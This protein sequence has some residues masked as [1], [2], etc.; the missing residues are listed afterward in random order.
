MLPCEARLHTTRLDNARTDND[1]LG[2]R[3]SAPHSTA[4]HCIALHGAVTTPRLAFHPR[5]AAQHR[6][7]NPMRLAAPDQGTAEMQSTAA[8]TADGNEKTGDVKLPP[9]EGATA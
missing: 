1:G 3:S 5:N 8:T 6:M 2:R 9:I 7:L 4:F